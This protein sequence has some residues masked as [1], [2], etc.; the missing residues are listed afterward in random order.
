MT[1]V[2]WKPYPEE[3]PKKTG[4]YLVTL[5]V[6]SNVY[7]TDSY[8]I[9]IDI[10]TKVYAKHPYWLECEGYVVAWADAPKPYNPEGKE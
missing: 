5:R 9:D 2:D 10:W 3:K 8:R 4:R 6:L 1:H 7:E